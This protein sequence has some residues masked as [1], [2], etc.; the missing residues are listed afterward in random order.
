MQPR[1]LRRAVALATAALLLTTVA[2]LAETVTADGDVVAPGVQASRYLGVASPG[3][4]IRFDVNFILACSGTSHVDATQMVRLTPGIITVPVGGSYGVGSLMFTPGAGW[5]AD[6]QACPAGLPPVTSPPIHVIITAPSDPGIGYRYSFTWNRSLTPPTA[7]D[8]GVFEGSPTNLVFT[9][10]VADNTPPTLNLPADSTIEGNT[11]NGALAAY[12]VSASDA[13]DAVAPTPSCSPAV[14]DLLP[15]GT[16]TIACTVADSGGMT[17]DGSFTITVV[18]TTAPVVAS[19]PDVELTS[20]DPSGAAVSYGLPSAVD[21][22]DPAP[23]VGCLPASGSTFAVGTTTVDCTATDASGNTSST[24]FDV[25][26]TYVAPVSWTAVWGEP[27]ATSGDSFVANPGRTVPIKVETFANGV[28]QTSGHA[29]LTVTPCGGGPA[30]TINLSR[31]TGRWTGKLDTSLLA[32]PGCYVAIVSLDGHAAGSFR[33]DLRGA[34]PAA[35]SSSAPTTGTS[36]GA[37]KGNGKGNG[38]P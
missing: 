29:V 11:T 20:G 24:S 16:N 23:T 22:V 13:E 31:D 14:G 33:M 18:D 28:E 38:K 3:Q 25:N 5:P 37:D 9:V 10:D 30:L 7:G 6:G 4:D 27:V 32:G 35:A 36:K 21:I 15:L 1:V 19:M 17:A 34:A 12:T 8:P 2:A 26:V